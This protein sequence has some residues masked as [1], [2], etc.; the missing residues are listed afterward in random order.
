MMEYD[1]RNDRLGGSNVISWAFKSR[2]ERQKRRQ[3]DSEHGKNF[4]VLLMKVKEIHDPESICVP[5]SWENLWPI[6]SNWGYQLSNFTK[7]KSVNILREL[8]KDLSPS[9]Q[10]KVQPWQFVDFTDLWHEKSIFLKNC[11]ICGCLL[12]QQQ[13]TNIFR[14]FK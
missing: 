6:A 13:K 9:S 2:R 5:S 1:L 3:Q 8:D 7:V 4:R 14:F 10:K 11:S 12:H